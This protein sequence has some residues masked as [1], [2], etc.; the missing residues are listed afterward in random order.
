MS[1]YS[2]GGANLGDNVLKTW[3][4][5]HYS[6]VEDNDRNLQTLRDR[7]YDLSINNAIGSAAINSELLGVLGS[8]LKLYPR[9]KFQELGLTAEAAREWAGRVKLEFEMWA[10]SP[11][12]DFYKRN[13]FYELQRIAFVSYLSDGDCFCLMRRHYPTVE[14]PYTLR[15]QMIEAG[16]VSNP[17]GA[18]S[19]VNQVEM[20]LPENQHR[21][22]NGVEIDRQGRICAVWISNRIWNEP[23]TVRPELRWQ[24]VKFFGK[25][26]GCRNVLHICFDTRTEQYRGVPFLAPV[27]RQLKQ[28]SRY[29]DAELASAIIKSY[30]SLFFIQPTSNFDFNDILPEEKDEPVVDI[31][32][33]RLGVGTISA[34][35]RGVDVKAIDRSNA[36]ST[37]SPFTD[38]FV[39]QVG[40]ALGISDQVLTKK[41]DASY[42]ASRAALLLAEEEFKQRRQ[43]FIADFC[44]PVY[45]QFLIEAIG[46]GRIEAAGFFEDA[47]KRRCW[48][49]SSWRGTTIPHIDPLKEI[50]AAAKRIELGLTTREQEAA[51]LGNDFYANAYDLKEEAKMIGGSDERDISVR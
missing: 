13:N 25:E 17:Q 30:F 48:L 14:M 27:I 29:G 50:N 36:Q 23:Q 49:E 8:G 20:L 10:G 12:C 3:Q 16:R 2:G 19:I 4:P 5:K 34:L 7:A 1:G 11:D 28:V 39:K 51:A 38:A 26:T 46:S 40:A 21:I 35:P 41:F 18:G 33:Y 15:L 22:I 31:R 47:V 42:S 37:F 45:E 32:D 6:A 24:R 44:E 43:A 9:I